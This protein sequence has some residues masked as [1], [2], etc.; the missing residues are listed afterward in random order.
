MKK[1][2]DIGYVPKR[3]SELFE[4]GM[5]IH[6]E[7]SVKKATMNLY[8][9]LEKE[10]FKFMLEKRVKKV[11]SVRHTEYKWSEGRADSYFKFFTEDEKAAALDFAKQLNEHVEERDFTV[12]ADMSDDEFLHFS[13][14]YQGENEEIVRKWR[15]AVRG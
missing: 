4:K 2:I 10:L 12:L 14:N 11:L 6:G 15:N 9:H 13:F 7:N 5:L 3:V 1:S 8:A